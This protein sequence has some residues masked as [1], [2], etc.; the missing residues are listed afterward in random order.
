[1]VH[2]QNTPIASRAVM[3]SFRLK[4]IAHQA[5]ASALILGIS[6]MEAPED[7]H[8]TGVGS[9]GLNERPYEHVEEDMEDCEHSQH[10][11][12]VCRVSD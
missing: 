8:L 12:V 9:H 2:I 11:D 7:W 3:A 6:Q 4:N 5:V 10:F 1:M